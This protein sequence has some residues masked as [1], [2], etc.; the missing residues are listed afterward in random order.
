M[1]ALPPLP[2]SLLDNLKA[3]Y[4]EPHRHYHTIAH[5]EALLRHLDTYRHLAA[6]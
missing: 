1:N 4:A 5:V 3:R 6:A 2:E